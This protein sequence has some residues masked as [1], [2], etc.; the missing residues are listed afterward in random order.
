MADHPDLLERIATRI[1]VDTVVAEDVLAT[2]VGSLAVGEKPE[3]PFMDIPPYFDRYVTTQI[4]HLSQQIAQ[5]RVE[6][7]RRFSEIDRRFDELRV[8]MDRRFGEM[9][10]RFDRLERWFFAVGIPIILGILAI[11]IK[12]FLGVP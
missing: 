4:F 5:L 1:G 10:R 2:L 7:D 3:R 9:D 8:E 11:I 6:V 12:I